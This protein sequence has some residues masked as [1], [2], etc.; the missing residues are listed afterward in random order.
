MHRI[1][2][3]IRSSGLDQSTKLYGIG[4]FIKHMTYII[5]I[6]NWNIPLLSKMDSYMHT[7]ELQDLG[8][9]PNVN[10]GIFRKCENRFILFLLV[11]A[12]CG[13]ASYI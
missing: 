5:N 12:L 10:V 6:N 9:E 1:H 13:N 4:S 7:T 8:Q 2:G 3:E 11:F